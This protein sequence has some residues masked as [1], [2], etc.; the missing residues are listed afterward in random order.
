MSSSHSPDPNRDQET[1][2]SFH[3]YVSNRQREQ[4]IDCLAR[5][6]SADHLDEHEFE[7]RVELANSATRL[8]ELQS[9]VKHLPIPAEHPTSRSEP[10]APHESPAETEYA[11][12]RSPPE[13]RD[14]VVSVFSGADRSGSWNLARRLHSVAVFGGNDIDLRAARFVP[15]ET[16]R[17]TCFVAFGGVDITVPQGVNL[18][19]RGIP[20]FGGFDGSKTDG[21][22][23]APTVIVSGLVLFGGVDVKAKAAKKGKSK[24]KR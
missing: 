3:D 5:N 23:D 10:A 1:V 20:I 24:N 6:Y 21:G 11:V 13:G 22:P 7:R 12:T 14:F 8:S 17:I 16:Y 15:G 2:L 19:V 9:L 18:V 4:Y